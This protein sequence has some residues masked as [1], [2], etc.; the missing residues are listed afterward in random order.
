MDSG[1]TDLLETTKKDKGN[2]GIGL[3]NVRRIVE[4]HHGEIAFL[5]ENGSME[6]DVMMYVEEL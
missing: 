1:R 4:K 5:Y 6:T 3:K 2:H